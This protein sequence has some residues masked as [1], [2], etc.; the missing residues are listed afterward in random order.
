MRLRLLLI[1]QVPWESKHSTNSNEKVFYCWFEIK[2]DHYLPSNS[3][4]IAH[5]KGISLYR[6]NDT[7]YPSFFFYLK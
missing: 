5:D 4:T 1:L 7:I 2:F 3:K 6:I